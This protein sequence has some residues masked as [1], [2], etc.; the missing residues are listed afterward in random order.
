MPW[1]AMISVLLLSV[2]V[3]PCQDDR[4]P[5]PISNSQPEVLLK[6][7]II[8]NEAARMYYSWQKRVPTSMK[9][10]GPPTAKT[11][12]DGDAAD[13]IS[14]DLASGSQGG[15]QFALTGKK[16]GWTIRAAPLTTDVR[17]D[18][19][20]TYTVETRILQPEKQRKSAM[21]KQ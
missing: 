16:S 19:Q 4:G 18:V 21:P 11:I 5:R 15:Y 1:K 3:V 2:G 12:A 6:R 17:E 9:Q 20:T 8:I 7:L 13:L 10:L 14:R